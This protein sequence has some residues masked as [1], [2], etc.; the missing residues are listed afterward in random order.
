VYDGE[1]TTAGLRGSR[2]A[3][4]IDYLG[5]NNQITADVEVLFTRQSN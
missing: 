4:L 2:A 1:I 3:E 5:A